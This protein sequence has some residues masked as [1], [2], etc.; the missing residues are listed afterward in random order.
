NADD[1]YVTEYLGA[2]EIP[3]ESVKKG[4]DGRIIGG[5][6]HTFRITSRS[7]TGKGALRLVQSIYVSSVPP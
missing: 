4:T 2:M 5:A 3:G 7:A 6:V 1:V